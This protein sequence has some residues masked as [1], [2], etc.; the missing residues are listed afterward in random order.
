MLYDDA[1]SNRLSGN[2]FV[3]G[4]NQDV[5]QTLPTCGN[6]RISIYD[7]PDPL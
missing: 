7:D 6:V 1:C 5:A 2:V 3:V 4:G